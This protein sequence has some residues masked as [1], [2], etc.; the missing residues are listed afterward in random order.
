MDYNGKHYKLGLQYESFERNI[1]KTCYSAE[2]MAA[3][4]YQYKV[5]D[6]HQQKT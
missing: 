3:I 1:V 4:V 2:E 6:E 5:H